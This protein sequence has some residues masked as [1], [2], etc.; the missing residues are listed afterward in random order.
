MTAKYLHLSFPWIVQYPT[1]TRTLNHYTTHYQIHFST[2]SHHLPF[3][4][5]PQAHLLC[6]ALP[7]NENCPTNDIR[8]V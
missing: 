8:T 3:K 6:T 4:D 1:R 2:L 7:R 5:I